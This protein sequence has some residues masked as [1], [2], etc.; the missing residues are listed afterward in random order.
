M[1]YVV[2]IF[3]TLIR[4]SG[5]AQ[6]P[7]PVIPPL[8]EYQGIYE[9]HQN[10]RVEIAATPRDTTML[11]A[12]IGV[13]KY[14]LHR[15]VADTFMNVVNDEVVFI[16]DS[17]GKV[18][19]FREDGSS[20]VMKLITA[21][22]HFPPEMWYPR[23]DMQGK[24]Y[25]YQ[26][27]RDLHDGLVPGDIDDTPLNK[28]LLEQMIN[29]I[30]DEKY[31]DIHSILILYDGRLVAEEYFYGYAADSLHQMRSATK[32]YVSMLT[33]IAIDEGY[34]SGTGAKVYDFF[35]EYPSFQNPSPMKDR[36][37]I[38][39]L[40]T[41]TSGWACDDWDMD[42]PGN[43]NTMGQ[44]GDWVKF[45]LD[46][47]VDHQ[48]G[49]TARY[50]SGGV[51]I[52]GRIIEKTSG[53][54]LKQFAGNYLFGPMGITDYKWDFKPDSSSAGTFCQLYLRP[55]DVAKCMLMVQDHGRW[56]G[57]QIV[58]ES[59]LK[60]SLS[61]N[62]SLDDTDY[63]YLWWLPYLYCEG[64]RFD[65]I[66]ATGNGGQKAYIWKD[67]NLITIFTGGNYNRDSGVAKLMV[68]Y[69]L[70]SFVELK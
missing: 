67:L 66:L 23:L 36:I 12:I 1:K 15:K 18:D 48:P 6:K 19:G 9:Y 27:P 17:A 51:I 45:I 49:D 59:W 8:L 40:L 7:A 47:P 33:G 3:L 28:R 24:P 16:R 63:G 54:D 29:D 65:A 21:H 57:R 55:R 22:V 46:L 20:E 44:Q 4:F 35:D 2:I 26:K 41:Q 43:E 64:K 42:S 13:A 38:R 30:L 53:D 69:I 62:S 60:E 50:C 10:S 39:D 14:P 37:T 5:M 34:L 31:E 52:T 70:P 56:Q 32:S 61:P 58:P 68:K 11:W 25:V